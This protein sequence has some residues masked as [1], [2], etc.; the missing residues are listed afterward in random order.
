VTQAL[1]AVAPEL[2]SATLRPDVPLR[3][4]VDLD[5]MDFLRFVMELHRRFGI[6]V[7][8]SDYRKLATLDGATDYLAAAPTK[9][10]PT[11]K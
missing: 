4:Q 10:P 6:D 11:A 1:S 9:T 2:A 3:E 5:S 8:E 7:P